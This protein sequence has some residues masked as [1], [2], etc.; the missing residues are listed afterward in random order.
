MDF[1]DVFISK[2]WKIYEHIM[3][4]WFGWSWK[5][6]LLNIETK[7]TERF[8]VWY[9]E[10]NCSDLIDKK[11]WKKAPRYIRLLWYKYV[12]YS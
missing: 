8:N 1:W 4:H 3:L 5:L 7:L 12:L 9:W 11:I 2:D 6:E 10:I